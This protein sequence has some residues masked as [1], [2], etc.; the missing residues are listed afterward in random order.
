MPVCNDLFHQDDRELVRGARD[1]DNHERPCDELAV[2]D[3][4]G[5]SRPRLNGADLC[6]QLPFQ[7]ASAYCFI[8]ALAAFLLYR[9]PHDL[10]DATDGARASL[11]AQE[12]R[13]MLCAATAWGVFYADLAFAP[14]VLEGRGQTVIAAAGIISI[15]SWIMIFSGGLWASRGLLWSKYGR[16]DRL[17]WRCH[18][19]AIASC[20]AGCRVER[21]LAFWPDWH[22]LRRVKPCG[23]RSGFLVWVF[24]LPPTMKSCWLRHLL[25]VQSLRPR[26][27][28]RALFGLQSFSSQPWFRWSQRSRNSKTCLTWVW[29]GN[30]DNDRSKNRCL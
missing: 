14:K 27:I 8:A 25:P 5:V 28:C 19:C 4:H 29:T 24:S 16:S 30:Y 10:P 2:E 3:R 23:R 20:D 7:V 17:H 26:A 15:G 6:R 9:Q 11:S 18:W 13:L 22:W 12:W 1:R 21:K